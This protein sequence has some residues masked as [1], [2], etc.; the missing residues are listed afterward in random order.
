MRP[1]IN[2]WSCGENHLW[3]DYPRN[4]L[5]KKILLIQI[6]EAS[7]LNDV[8]YNIPRNSATLDGREVDH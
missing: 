8:T 4:P 1:P 6:K 3:R 2:C 7:T 5:K